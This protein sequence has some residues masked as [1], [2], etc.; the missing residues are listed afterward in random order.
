[1]PPLLPSMDRRS[2]GLC[3]IDDAGCILV[4]RKIKSV[5]YCLASTR[6]GFVVQ[7]VQGT[8]SFRFVVLY[9]IYNT[10]LHTRY[11]H[12]PIYISKPHIYMYIYNY[13]LL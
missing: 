5:T 1:M 9:T 6:V 3:V 12:I 13:Y 2:H 4:E 10:C 11:V 8:G 7:D